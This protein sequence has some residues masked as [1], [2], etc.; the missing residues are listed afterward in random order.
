MPAGSSPI[1]YSI[2]QAVKQADSWATATL[3]ARDPSYQ[4]EPAARDRSLPSRSWDRLVC[5]PSP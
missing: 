4:P 5:A 1:R 3:A 2:E